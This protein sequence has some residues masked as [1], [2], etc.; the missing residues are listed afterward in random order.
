MCIETRFLNRSIY[1]IGIFGMFDDPRGYVHGIYIFVEH[2]IRCIEISS[3]P[4]IRRSFNATRSIIYS[5]ISF[6]L[7]ASSN[8]SS[9]SSSS[10]SCPFCLVLKCYIYAHTLTHIIKENSKIVMLINFELDVEMRDI[11]PLQ[12]T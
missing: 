4:N 3:R 5:H 7:Y 10:S 11:K 2:S 1:K 12:I 9:S 6:H 8:F